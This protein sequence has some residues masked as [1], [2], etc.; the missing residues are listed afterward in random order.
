MQS[1]NDLCIPSN[2]NSQSELLGYAVLGVCLVCAVL[3][4]YVS[5]TF[6]A[7][8]VASLTACLITG[9]NYRRDHV[10]KEDAMALAKPH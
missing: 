10:M 4:G 5:L 1:S 8:I 2:L 3:T 7:G 6:T 9:S